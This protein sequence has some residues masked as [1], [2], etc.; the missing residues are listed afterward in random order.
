M[1]DWRLNGQEKYLAGATY[2]KVTF[3]QFWKKAYKE[4]NSFFQAI[5]Q[6]AKEIVAI[7]NEGHEFLEGDKIQHFWHQHCEFCM[8]TVT[9]DKECVF[10]YTPDTE[11]WICETCFRDFKER[12]NFR[13]KT[14]D[15][16][17]F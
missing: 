1:S 2:Y 15:E 14:E 9:T 4:K 7:T 3:P 10:Y 17:A 8:E 6:D 16:L 11:A 5:W 13:E 12:F